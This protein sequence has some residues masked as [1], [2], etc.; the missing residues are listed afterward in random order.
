MSRTGRRALAVCLALALLAGVIPAAARA[1]GGTVLKKS[2]S[3]T[4]TEGIFDVELEAVL[5]RDPAA[6][7]DDGGQAVVLVLEAS[8]RAEEA[9]LLDL[10]REAAAAFAEGL[11][12]T[13]DRGR[14]LAV[15][16]Y[17]TNVQTV[18]P[19]TDV[20][21]TDGVQ[22]RRALE[23]EFGA[24]FPFGTGGGA[25][26]DT[27][28]AN[29]QGG[30]RLARNL[31]SEQTAARRRVIVLSTG[32]PTACLRSPGGTDTGGLPGYG[33]AP[34]E[35]C[36]G[37]VPAAAGEVRAL[38]ELQVFLLAD[39]AETLCV[40]TV[41]APCP[42]NNGGAHIDGYRHF[43]GDH[44][45]ETQ[46]PL[47][48]S[49]W[50]ARLADGF[51]A[52]MDGE[53]LSADL[54]ALLPPAAQAPEGAWAV[55]DPVAAP[56]ALAELPQ[57]ARADGAGGLVWDLRQAVPVA[58][59][60]GTGARTYRLGYRLVLD[61]AH[62]AFQS[63]APCPVG[64]AVLRVP[65]GAGTAEL[66]SKD[67]GAVTGWTGAFSFR[68][69]AFHDP[70]V[71][72]GVLPEGV[73]EA[74]NT[75]E[76]ILYDGGAVAARAVTV[77]SLVRFADLPSG[78]SYL[79]R[80]T[81]FPPGYAEKDENWTVDVARG[82]VTVTDATGA[83]VLGPDCPELTVVDALDPAPRRFTVERRWLPA[84]CA[85]AAGGAVYLKRG[86]EVAAVCAPSPG[87]G[88]RDG[89]TLPTVDPATGA[90]IT[91]TVE[92]EETPG[93][94]AAALTGWSEGAD[95][96]SCTLTEVRR[97]AG[98]VE[99]NVR[100]VAPE[101]FRRPVE[102]AL[103][104][105]DTERGRV[106]LEAGNGWRGVLEGVETYDGAGE[107]IG[108]TLRTWADGQAEA[109]GALTVDGRG[110]AAAY[111][112]AG[113]AW[114]V[115]YTILQERTDRGGTVAW[116]AAALAG[117]YTLGATVELWADGAP[118]GRRA[119]VT[120]DGGY[121]FAGLER[122][123]LARE[124]AEISYTARLAGAADGV[125]AWNGHSF[126]V[127]EEAGDFVL[128]LT[129]EAW[130]SG[131]VRWVDR[132]DAEGLRPEACRVRLLCG[133]APTGQE[134]TLPGA[135]GWAFDFGPQ[136]RYDG[137]G[138]ELWYETELL[139]PARCPYTASGGGGFD[140]TAVLEGEQTAVFAEVRWV[141]A[142]GAHPALPLAVYDGEHLVEVWD[143]AGPAVFSLPRYRDGGAVP[144]TVRALGPD[145]AALE[146]GAVFSLPSGDYGA[147][148]RRKGERW[149]VVCTVR[150]EDSAC[151]RA[152]V[153]WAD[154][155]PEHR[156]AAAY[157]L[158]ADGRETGRM[159][160]PAP[161]AGE[162]GFER[163]P[164]YDLS[165]GGCR[166]IA[167][168]LR[169]EL[170]GP[171]APRYVTELVRAGDTVYVTNTFDPGATA[172]QGTVR[173]VCGG[174]EPGQALAL[175][176][177]A[178]GVQAA[179]CPAWSGG[180]WAY[181][182]PALPAFR[183][184]GERISYE[185][186]PEG[187]DGDGLDFDGR[188]WTVA[189]QGGDFTCTLAQERVEI[190]VSC[191]WNGPEGERAVFSL[192]RDGAQVT[193]GGAPVL[194]ELTAGTGWAGRF[195]EVERYGDD[196][197]PYAYTAR[198]EGFEA[199][200]RA[201]DWF[202]EGNH[203]TATVRQSLDAVAEGSLRWEGG[204][205]PERVEIVLL[206]DGAPVGQAVTADAAGGW[207]WRFEGLPRYNGAHGEIRYTAALAGAVSAGYETWSVR[208]GDDCFLAYYGGMDILARWYSS[209][210]Y[211]WHVLRRYTVVTD[212]VP[213]PA[214][215][216]QE[217]LRYGARGEVVALDGLSAAWT[218]YGGAAYRLS[219][220]SVDGVPVM[221]EEGRFSFSL[222]EANVTRRVL[223]YYLRVE[224][225][226]APP[227][228]PPQGGGDAGC[229]G[230]PGDGTAP[231]AGGAAPA[232]AGPALPAP[233]GR[234]YAETGADGVV[235]ITARPPEGAG[236][237]FALLLPV[238]PAGPGL[239]PVD[240]EG[241]PVRRSVVRGGGLYLVLDGEAV[242][243][244]ED[245]GVDF[246]DLPEGHWAGAAAR[247][248]AARGLLLGTGAEYFSPD[249]LMTRGMLAAALARLDGSP[250][251]PAQADPVPLTRQALA[252]TLWYWLEGQG[253]EGEAAQLGIF[254]DA[255]GLE[256]PRAV[257]CAV[258]AGLLGGRACGGLEPQGTATRAE[259][260][261]VLRRAVEALTLACGP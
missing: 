52:P 63:G 83:V 258:G 196:R 177:L 97:A 42:N 235:R 176:L 256:D 231:G 107:P 18:L 138:R 191:L 100:W 170:S 96:L 134:L 74:Q 125:Y 197:R 93:F 147:S 227:P 239:V 7:P 228:N 137:D 85:P 90:A 57:G 35:Q 109:G 82:V 50:L 145:G 131:A 202:R 98:P 193:A 44:D 161:G 259:T 172:R 126:A 43:D 184:D 144:Y 75:A 6:P 148:Y 187:L 171:A 39:G 205:E 206:A 238:G 86:R 222:D 159:A 118:T 236:G 210:S 229:G 255:E 195:P 31:L 249:A 71:V 225:A 153:D 30:L 11:A 149:T 198:L 70:E 115:T 49:G 173:W 122:Y 78:R 215:S 154:G 232:Q 58:V 220:V 112:H 130:V 160:V 14:M 169:Q 217:P 166:R 55:S 99:I 156:P 203:F 128:T 192:W 211:S 165:G 246:S 53:A 224:E 91:Y 214:G 88:W 40:E 209:D 32:R 150:Q 226:P 257:A 234:V 183:G 60:R 29:L 17:G 66:A 33:D 139:L 233:Q 260:A 8:V 189:A 230:K 221:P 73:Q 188:R 248:A 72:F 101:D 242:L 142:E 168:S 247:W 116:R 41:M 19:W 163:L 237:P 89:A 194:L 103:M 254:P 213:A 69:A 216:V 132:E 80:Q 200:S 28:A 38:G 245:R 79:L 45:I 48:L 51:A 64:R 129:G 25:V 119:D 212:G 185:V 244:L 37:T 1:E 12:G 151:L 67:P 157:F 9:E 87:S 243:T 155:G 167:Y 21:G 135:E 175:V 92:A 219:A 47:P 61:S 10:E 158:L 152:V 94:R 140:Q 199:G 241:V 3:P 81:R 218:Q 76:F 252:R 133:G 121:T 110:Y 250:E 136:P 180:G 106:R 141:D 84:Q 102:A 15:V 13:A 162:V 201:Y 207:R 62:P 46:R 123:D 26:P 146:E 181:D 186:R 204:H 208:Y 56:L 104:E 22:A 178:D 4:D 59:D 124:G 164:V 77:N 95:G 65:D 117:V 20:A 23:Q 16:Q 68:V 190:A 127:A 174:A 179:R 27:G 5:D 2:V 111:E 223:L 143:G 108:Y 54:S 36:W 120:G 261:V 253:L 240:E 113:A 114:T 105:G 182:F 34:D 251:P 24:R